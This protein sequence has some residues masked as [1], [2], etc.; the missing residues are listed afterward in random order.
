MATH[1]QPQLVNIELVLAT[2]NAGK[3]RE[4]RKLTNDFPVMWRS[5]A[6][7]DSFI[8]P[9]ETGATFVENALIKAVA[10]WNQSGLPS[11]ADDSGLVVDALNG[12]PGVHSARF[13][14]LHGDDSA[15]IKLLLEKLNNV[16]STERTAHFVCAM[17]LVGSQADPLIRPISTL[18]SG[19]TPA[20]SVDHP[21]K[22]RENEPPKS[23]SW[24]CL[25]AHP[26]L[27]P[28]TFA[29]IAEGRVEGRILPQPCGSGGFGYDPIF[30]YPPL[31]KTFAE[32]S[33]DEKN[34]FSH[35]AA[36]LTGLLDWL[37]PMPVT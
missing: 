3:V 24:R 35:R 14:G 27:P 34:Q 7:L 19:K 32:L 36:A 6:D 28:D 16:D 11:V 33:T 4:V 17:V 13:A 15:N 22:L 5:L 10:A 1:V 21:N 9:D 20:D 18:D 8:P 25:T 30:F 31:R 26:L 12:A 23:Q 2:A 29:I 37:T